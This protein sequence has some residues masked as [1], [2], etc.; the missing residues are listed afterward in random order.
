VTAGRS[1]TGGQA[2]VAALVAGG[3]RHAFTVP[4]ESFLGVLDALHD[5]PI[6]TIATRHE[7]GAAFMA[8]AIGQLTGRPAACLATRA[9]GA[10]N[11]AIGLHTA[12]ADS[13][14]LIALVGQVPRAFRGREAFQEVDQVET[15]G[16]L[17]KAAAEV[18]EPALAG[19]ETARLLALARA[20]R[21]GPVLVALP[22]DLLDELVVAP[23]PPDAISVPAEP[24][25]PAPLPAAVRSV[26]AELAGA[27]TPLIVVGAGVRRSAAVAELKA[28]AEAALL[29]VVAA[30]RRP[31]GFDNEHPFY[32]GMSGLGAA[33]SVRERLERADVIL[34]LGTRLNEVA[35][36]DYAVPGARTRLL[37]VDIEPGFPGERRQPDVAVRADARTFLVAALERIGQEPATGL[38]RDAG[39]RRRAIAADR[40]AY[41]AASTPPERPAGDGVDPASVIRGVNALLPDDAVITTDAGNFGGWY[42]RYLRIR[43]GQR[44]LGP[45]SGAM[46]YALPAAIGAAAAEPGRSVVAL[47]GDGGFAMLMAELETAVRE[48]LRL[49]VLVH[50]NAMYGTIRAHQERAHPGRVI[51]TQLGPVDFAAVAEACGAAAIR[52]HDEAQ[53]APALAA[54]FAAP[55]VTVVHLHMDRRRLSVDVTTEGD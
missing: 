54:A 4:G 51:A 30:W 53:V 14:P 44:F 33:T 29:P 46:G 3:V 27:Q 55:G 8:E 38:P 15:F 26:L 22:E 1:L 48:G 49:A 21:P 24:E 12:R 6:R 31:D 13:A 5:A 16:R 45:T 23:P 20:G 34:A 19:P 42:T 7:G 41:V 10:A 43:P 28:F 39:A 18:A 50:D 35:T 11:L 40:A 9:V 32:L 37:Q 25:R 2:V 47:A 52:V 17:C 36:Y